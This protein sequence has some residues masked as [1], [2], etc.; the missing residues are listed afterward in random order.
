MSSVVFVRIVGK[1]E[2]WGGGETVAVRYGKLPDRLITT[3]CRTHDRVLL[4]CVT[5]FIVH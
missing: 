1:A 3:F 2:A 4:C 5:S